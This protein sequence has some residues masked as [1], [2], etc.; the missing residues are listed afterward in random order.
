MENIITETTEQ[1]TS[2]FYRNLTDFAPNFVFAQDLELKR[3]LK[4]TYQ[5]PQIGWYW[6]DSYA[7]AE[8]F[9]NTTD[10]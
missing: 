10:K 1:D 9:F 3:E 2:G 5:Y 4:D 8:A 7:L 6:F